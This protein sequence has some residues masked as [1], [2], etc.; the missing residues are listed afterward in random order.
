[1]ERGERIMGFGHAVY[2]TDDPRSRLLRDIAQSLGGDLVQL[3]VEVE[4]TVLRSWPS[5]NRATRCTPT[6]S[7]TPAWSWTGAA[8]PGSCSRRPSR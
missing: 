6:L 3:A 8:S 4:Q 5:S 1:M 2:R 7:S